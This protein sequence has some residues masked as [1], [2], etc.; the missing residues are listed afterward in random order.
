MK[1]WPQ[2][3]GVDL[4]VGLALAIGLIVCFSI[5][6]SVARRT[7]RGSLV[8]AAYWV[9]ILY[10][11]GLALASAICLLTH[12]GGSIFYGLGL[13]GVIGALFGLITGPWLW[14]ARRI[15]E[16]QRICARDL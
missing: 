7:R 3:H 11:S 4:L 1:L 10:C 6:Q 13:A 12:R 8:Q 2:L 5:I 14:R 9:L 16:E 15:A